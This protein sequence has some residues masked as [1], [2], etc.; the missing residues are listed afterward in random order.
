MSF[1]SYQLT[2][3]PGLVVV[4]HAPHTIRAYLVD[5]INYD[6]YRFHTPFQPVTGGSYDPGPDGVTRVHLHA[7]IFNQW[8]LIVD[9]PVTANPQATFTV[10]PDT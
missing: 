7:P 6:R 9:S 5:A 8:W 2:A 4:V 3:G 10:Q 1:L